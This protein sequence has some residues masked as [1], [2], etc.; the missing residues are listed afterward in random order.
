MNAT[1]LASWTF[2]LSLIALPATAGIVYQDDFNGTGGPLNG[3]MPDISTTGAVWEATDGFSDDGSAT[4]AGGADGGTAAHLNLALEAGKIYTA[5]ATILNDQLDWIAFGFTVADIDWTVGGNAEVRH[6]NGGR[7]ATWILTRNSPNSNDQEGF[8]GA[9]TASVQPWGGDVVDPT[10]PVDIKV[11]LDNT[12][13]VSESEFWLN[14]V[15]QSTHTYG[16]LVLK[17]FDGAADGGDDAGGIGFSHT[18]DTD[19]AF[20]SLLSFKVSVVPEPA[21]IVL[22]AIGALGLG[23]VRKR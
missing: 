6:S 4:N 1:R 18:S 23:L 19:G 2:V 5:E 15:L 21:S 7:G 20:G 17:D 12:G 14:G 13:A 9:G 8:G 16:S 3:T 22:V 10:E 11:V